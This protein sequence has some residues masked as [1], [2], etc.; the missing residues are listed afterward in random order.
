M[1]ITFVIKFVGKIFGKN[2]QSGQILRDK[3]WIEETL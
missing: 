3:I 2:I 1:W